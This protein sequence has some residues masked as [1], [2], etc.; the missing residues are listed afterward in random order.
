MADERRSRFSWHP[1]PELVGFD[2]EGQSRPALERLGDAA[3]TACLDYLY[4][5]ALR[6]PV[7][8]DAYPELRRRLFP[9]GGP[10]PAPLHPSPSREV[11]DEFRRI[12]PFQFNSHH[13]RAY[14]YFTPPP[15]LLSIV[16]E[17]LGQWVNQGVDIWHAAPSAALVE[18]EVVRWLTDLVGY[19][20]ESFGV[21]T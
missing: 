13:R 5:E 7:G 19:G 17:L 11:L 14:S 3:W 16:G 6:R 20:P 8:P 21:L 4:G 10:A 15:L 12:A 1:E 9:T 2:D 18:E